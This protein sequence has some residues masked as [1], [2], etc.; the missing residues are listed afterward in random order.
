MR[1]RA[2]SLLVVRHWCE[3]G[4]VQ[5]ETPRRNSRS[6][7]HGSRNSR[8]RRYGPGKLGYAPQKRNCNAINPICGGVLDE[9]GTRNPC[10]QSCDDVRSLSAIVRASTERRRHLSKIGCVLQAELNH[11]GRSSIV[12]VFARSVISSHGVPFRLPQ[13]NLSASLDSLAPSGLAGFALTSLPDHLETSASHAIALAGPV[14]VPADTL[15]RLHDE[16][17]SFRGVSSIQRQT[18]R[19]RLFGILGFDFRKGCL[20]DFQ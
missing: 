1:R 13:E 5:K 3:P 10:T 2:R 8:V 15:I 18:L 19:F 7:R 17:P 14:A 4:I 6:E 9:A 11:I 12:P 20:G 16:S